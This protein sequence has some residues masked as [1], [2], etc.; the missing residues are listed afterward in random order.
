VVFALDL[1]AGFRLER[2]RVDPDLGGQRRRLRRL[3]D[4]TFWMGGI[5]D[6]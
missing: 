3:P 5:E 4:K 2:W 1:G 6:V